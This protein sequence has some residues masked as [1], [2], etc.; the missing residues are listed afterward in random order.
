MTCEV[1]K[2]DLKW[3]VSYHNAILKITEEYLNSAP[4]GVGS[5]F[6]QNTEEYNYNKGCYEKKSYRR[7]LTGFSL[8]NCL[9]GRI[10][11]HYQTDVVGRGPSAD[12]SFEL[13]MLY[14][15]TRGYPRQLLASR[16]NHGVDSDW[17]TKNSITIEQVNKTDLF[18]DRDGRNWALTRTREW[19]T[20]PFMSEEEYANTGAAA[21]TTYER[22]MKD[23]KRNSLEG[24]RENLFKQLGKF[25]FDSAIER[26][27]K[28]KLEEVT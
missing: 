3:Y 2:A 15:S 24:I 14:G 1:L 10:T 11:V 23:W 21:Y 20:R 6:Q 26:R 4:V 28:K 5:L 9:D 25:D 19:A 13:L 12:K 27:R 7:I 17:V 22:W 18:R 8:V 16:C